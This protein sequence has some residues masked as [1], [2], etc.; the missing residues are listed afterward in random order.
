VRSHE[1]SSDFPRAARS[2]VLQGAPPLSLDVFRGLTMFLLIG[3]SAHLCE[4]LRDPSLAGTLRHA[5]GTPLEH[6]PWA[7]LWSSCFWLC[8]RRILIRV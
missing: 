8:R 4:R 6:H 5:I 1:S 2:G 7:V 3:E